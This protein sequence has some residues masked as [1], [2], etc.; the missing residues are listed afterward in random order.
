[1]GGVQAAELQQEIDF[2][3][4]FYAGAELVLTAPARAEKSLEEAAKRAWH[5][6]LLEALNEEEDKSPYA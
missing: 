2:H 6:T 3:R 4:G 1:M 5:E